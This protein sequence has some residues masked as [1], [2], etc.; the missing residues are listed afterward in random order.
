ME[1]ERDIAREDGETKR[2]ANRK[3]AHTDESSSD[4]R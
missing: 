2:N 4:E 1:T 3:R